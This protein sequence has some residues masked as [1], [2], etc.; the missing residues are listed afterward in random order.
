MPIL[1]IYYKYTALSQISK[2]RTSSVLATTPIFS[3]ENCRT[4]IGS[5]TASSILISTSLLLY[6]TEASLSLN[7]GLLFTYNY[8]NDG[9][10]SVTPNIIYQ[11]NFLVTIKSLKRKYLTDEL[12]VLE[13]TY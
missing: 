12:R 11:N 5:L 1:N 2:Y 6:Q 13:L 10:E 8:I 3:D 4:Q 9:T 7:N